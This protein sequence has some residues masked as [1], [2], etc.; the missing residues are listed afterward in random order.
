MSLDLTV[1]G[2][3]EEVDDVTMIV[4]KRVPLPGTDEDSA[5][6]ARVEPAARAADHVEVR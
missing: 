3:A 4:L 1:T 6:G 5:R 2:D